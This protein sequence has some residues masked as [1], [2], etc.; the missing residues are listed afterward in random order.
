M[1]RARMVYDY[2]VREGTPEHRLQYNGYGN[3]EMRFP[4]ATTEQQ[5]A[6]NRRVEIRILSTG[7]VIS[8]QQS[9][10]IE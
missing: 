5:Q 7:K 10:Q 3:W 1:N 6:L 9:L 8:K 2:L 4:H